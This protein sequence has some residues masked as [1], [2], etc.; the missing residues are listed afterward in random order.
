MMKKWSLLNVYI[1]KKGKATLL[2]I[3]APLMVAINAVL[4]YNLFLKRTLNINF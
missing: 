2:S 4:K 3:F 1:I